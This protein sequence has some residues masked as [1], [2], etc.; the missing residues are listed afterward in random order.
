MWRLQHWGCSCWSKHCV[1]WLP[2]RLEGHLRVRADAS[3]LE[4]SKSLSIEWCCRDCCLPEWMRLA[5]FRRAVHGI[6]LVHE[7]CRQSVACAVV[8][9]M[10]HGLHACRGPNVVQPREG[11]LC[12]HDDAD[13]VR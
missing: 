2:C 4:V 10:Q 6:A 8:T 5:A 1:W 9:S 3:V 12:I 11:V 13:T 7:Q